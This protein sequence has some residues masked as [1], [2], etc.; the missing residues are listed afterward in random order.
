MARQSPI[1]PEWAMKPTLDQ[2]VIFLATIEQ[3]S[4]VKAAQVL[5]LRGATVVQSSNRRMANALGIQLFHDNSTRLTEA[6]T[7]CIKLAKRVVNTHKYL[8]Q[9]MRP[10]QKQHCIRKPIKIVCQSW[11]VADFMPEVESAIKLLDNYHI[12]T[13]DSRG[14]EVEVIQAFSLGKYDMMV[15]ANDPPNVQT[16]PLC[17][18]PL[19]P[20][21]PINGSFAASQP[22]RVI[23][24][25]E[26]TRNQKNVAHTA[27][28]N[29]TR[30]VAYL[31]SPSEVKYA[32]AGGAGI[33]FV[34][35]KII[36]PEVEKLISD[37][38]VTEMTLYAILK[39]DSP[40]NK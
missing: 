29:A 6:G 39:P 7:H 33:G 14:T 25:A 30:F 10:L 16:I 4:T 17:T 1:S 19:V 28:G 31:D 32:V 35:E 24:Y 18:I 15:T 38:P 21:C 26:N 12:H 9:Q 3:G 20:I 23:G 22:L 37:I 36:T 11:I 27:C 13:V 34:P 40:Y 5:G 2:L 8:R